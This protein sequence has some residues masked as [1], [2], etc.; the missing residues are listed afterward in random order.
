MGRTPTQNTIYRRDGALNRAARVGQT[1]GAVNRPVTWTRNFMSMTSSTTMSSAEIASARYFFG[2]TMAAL[3]FAA[4]GISMLSAGIKAMRAS[5]KTI[6]LLSGAHTFGYW[7]FEHRSPSAPRNFP[8]A[9]MQSAQ[10]EDESGN[11]NRLT[12]AQYAQV[13][14]DA[15]SDALQQFNSAFRAMGRNQLEVKIREYSINADTTR[16]STDELR[17]MLKVF[18]CS[19]FDHDPTVAGLAYLMSLPSS[20]PRVNVSAAAA[21]YRHHPYSI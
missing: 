14:T 8:T 12:A 10:L 21:N 17:A 15:H 6:A 20:E 7:L 1:A 9:L 5:R 11:Y 2:P 18:V 19:S 16:L 13:W 3:G 4:V